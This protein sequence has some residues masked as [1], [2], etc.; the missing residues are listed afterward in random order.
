[1]AVGLC[2]Y[3]R[4]KLQ[5]CPLRDRIVTGSIGEEAVTG[6]GLGAGVI[7]NSFVIRLVVV[8]DV[9]SLLLLTIR[10]NKR[11]GILEQ[12]VDCVQAS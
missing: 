1:M 12:Y 9:V 7:S 3:K 11:A 8:V 10:T 2:Q 5:G 4:L 6:A